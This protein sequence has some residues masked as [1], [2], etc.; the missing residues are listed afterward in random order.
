MQ[1]NRNGGNMARAAGISV[2]IEIENA[3]RLALVRLFCL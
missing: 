3:G 1:L 2:K